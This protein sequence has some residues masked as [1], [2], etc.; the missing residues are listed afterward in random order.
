MDIQALQE[1][2]V[3]APEDIIVV[4]SHLGFDE[5]QIR[6]NPQKHLI[7]APRPYDDA[8][9]P[10]GFLLYT[11]NLKWLYTT[12]S[13]K[14]N[15]FS[16]V[17]QLKNLTFPEALS[18]I[19]K[20]IGYKDIHRHIQLPFKGFFK[21]LEKEDDDYDD[22][23]PVYDEKLLPPADSLSLKFFKDGIA[24]QVQERW[25]VRYDHNTDSI[26][27]PIH[28]QMG[29]LVGCKAR[30]NDP[31]CDFN[32]R[33][34]AYLEYNKNQILFGIFENYAHIMSKDTVIVLESEKAP[35]QAESFGLRCCAAI[36]GHNISRSQAKQ[37]VGL[38]VKN[39]ILAFDEGISEEEIREQCSVLDIHNPF[40]MPNIYYLYDRDHKYLK[41]GSKNAPTDLGKQGML[42]L[43][44]D[45]KIQYQREP[46]IQK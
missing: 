36:A 31:N 30:N 28:N 14:G 1:R 15:L 39:I 17:M 38:G 35:M 27:I 34:W 46:C 11:D 41:E 7:S 12:R 40:F 26:L 9:N 23:L 22:D 29:L 21:K 2:L 43:L 3:D 24:L 6:F 37:I 13:G 20:W 5:A 10:K 19:A 45:C 8:D 25:G 32:H 44:K 18:T 33:W 4:L 42:G 16:L